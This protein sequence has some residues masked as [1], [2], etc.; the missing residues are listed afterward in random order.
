MLHKLL[1]AT[2]LTGALIAPASATL[3]IAANIGPDTFFCADGQACDSSG[4]SNLIITDNTILDGI[5]FSSS[6]ASSASGATDFLNASNL[7]I[8]NTNAV[9]VDIT[10]TVSNTNFTAPVSVFASADSGVWQGSALSTAS[11]KWFIDSANA[12]GADNAFDTPGVLVDTDFATSAGPVFAFSRNNPLIA[13]AQSSPF[14]MTEQLTLHLGAGESIVNRGQT[15]IGS[16]IPE[17]ST[18]AMLGLGTLFLAL[19]ARRRQ[20]GR[21]AL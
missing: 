8:T 21:F 14:S 7:L 13:S 6:S 3:Q 17:P 11:M 18:W 12:Q 5:L 10:I 20:N 2:A 16:A 19:V 9:P 15:I 1:L 4:T